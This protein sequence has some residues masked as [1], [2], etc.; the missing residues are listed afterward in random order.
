MSDP[1][2]DQL[3]GPKLDAEEI[4]RILKSSESAT[5]HLAPLESVRPKFSVKSN[6]ELRRLTAVDLVESGKYTNIEEAMED[7]RKAGF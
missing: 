5:D 3:K 2:G 1:N 6:E 7:L 4:R